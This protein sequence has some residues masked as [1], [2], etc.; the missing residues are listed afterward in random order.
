M[1]PQE[2]INQPGRQLDF[3]RFLSEI[4]LQKKKSSSF[5]EMEMAILGAVEELYRR[6]SEGASIENSYTEENVKLCDCQKQVRHESKN[7]RGIRIKTNKAIFYVAKGWPD[8]QVEEKSGD[9]SKSDVCKSQSAVRYF[10][11]F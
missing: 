9:F 3:K 8:F 6:R 7:P 11:C 4:R 2:T 5:E 1:R 10:V